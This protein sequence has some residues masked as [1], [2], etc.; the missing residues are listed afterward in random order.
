[1]QMDIKNQTKEKNGLLSPWAMHIYIH[2]NN[3]MNETTSLN[4]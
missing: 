1:M 3:M 2:L 4:I